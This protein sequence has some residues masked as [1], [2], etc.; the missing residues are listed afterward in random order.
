MELPVILSDHADWPDLLTT[1]SEIKPK[2]VWI[3]HG[4]EDALLHA[5]AQLGITAGAL[6]LI[7][8]EEASE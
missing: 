3:T 4:R 2:E 6:S 5:C 1:L 7:G 8:Y